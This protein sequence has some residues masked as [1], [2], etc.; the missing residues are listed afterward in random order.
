MPYYLFDLG[1]PVIAG[2]RKGTVISI[3]NPANKTAHYLVRLDNGDA[4]W[5]S[6][7]EVI[8]P[9]AETLLGKLKRFLGRLA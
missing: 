6:R 7:W 1:D 3:G 9:S 2:R 8:P 4:E 5:F